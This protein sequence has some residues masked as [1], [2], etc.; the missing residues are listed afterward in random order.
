MDRAIVFKDKK[1]NIKYC[2]NDTECKNYESCMCPGGEKNK[3]W[4]INQK[5]R[6]MHKSNL[7]HDAK[8]E[9]SDVDLIDMK[10]LSKKMLEFNNIN[11]NEN[12]LTTFKEIERLARDCAYYNSTD[13]HDEKNYYLHYYLAPHHYNDIEHFNFNNIN[14][15]YSLL[16]KYLMFIILILFIGYQI[17]RKINI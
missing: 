4:C 6:C 7:L 13:N 12:N 17:H 10:C 8:K 9:L 15:N 2:N 11:N 5:R 1:N 16:Y 3:E 14:N